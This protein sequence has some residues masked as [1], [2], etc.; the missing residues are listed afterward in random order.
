MKT[1]DYLNKFFHFFRDPRGI[2]LTCTLSGT[3]TAAAKMTQRNIVIDLAAAQHTKTVTITTPIAF[4]V[5][6]AH[7]IASGTTDSGLAVQNGSTAITDAI[8]HG[9]ADKA[10][11]NAGTIDDA[12]YA[13]AKDD[14]D[15]TLAVTT[16][17]FTGVLVLE[18]VPV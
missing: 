11:V 9:T 13:F 5:L 2:D 15:L 18:I 16:A 1:R 8:A 17:A 4:K 7:I 6:N 12:Q 10:V 3:G 14:D